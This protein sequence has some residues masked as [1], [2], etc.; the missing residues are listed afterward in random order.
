MWCCHWRAAAAAAWTTRSAS[1]SSSRRHAGGG[2]RGGGGGG[3]GD[4]CDLQVLLQHLA[5]TSSPASPLIAKPPATLQ[6]TE[7]LLKEQG[8]IKEGAPARRL[9]WRRSSKKAAAADGSAQAPVKPHKSLKGFALNLCEWGPCRRWAPKRQLLA[10]TCGCSVATAID[11]PAPT[12]CLARLPA[13]PL[14][15]ERMPALPACPPQGRP[16][17]RR[18]RRRARAAPAWWS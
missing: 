15:R 4:L 16:W 7:D 17:T 3:R 8:V 9:S 11:T 14:C 1:P 6:V 13:C 5:R 2:G 12:L 18:P 10:G